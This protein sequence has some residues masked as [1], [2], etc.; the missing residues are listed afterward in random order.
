M[1]DTV[2]AWIFTATGSGVLT[3]SLVNFV[4]AVLSRRWPHATGTVIVSDLQRSRD[5]E[6]EYSYRPE[7]SYQYSVKGEEFI[8]TR[9]RYGDR[10]ALSWPAPA[11][12]MVRRYPVGAV[13]SVHYDPDEPAEAVLEPG[14]N[15]LILTGAAL[16]GLFTFLGIVALRS[17]P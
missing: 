14:V 13:V 10:L 3:W 9:T 2:I 12:K 6:G 5:S 1:L 4:Y 16:G 17:S 11:A 15:G 7:V 8:A